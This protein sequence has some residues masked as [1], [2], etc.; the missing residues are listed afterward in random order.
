M[1]G[2]PD[3]PGRCR[4]GGGDRHSYTRRVSPRQRRYIIPAALTV[5]IVIVV[6]AQIVRG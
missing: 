2:G 3:Q 4:I 6:V 1:E 5:L